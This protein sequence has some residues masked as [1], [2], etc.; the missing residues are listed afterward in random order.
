MFSLKGNAAINPQA[1]INGNVLFTVD[2]VT[3]NGIKFS[4]KAK[5]TNRVEGIFRKCVRLSFFA[6]KL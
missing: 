6:K 4:T 1:T 5:W 2:S 3:Y